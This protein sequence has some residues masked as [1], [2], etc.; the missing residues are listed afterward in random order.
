MP[1]L[2]PGCRKLDPSVQD[3][4]EYTI[5]LCLLCHSSLERGEATIGD[6]YRASLAKTR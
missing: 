6:Q 2:C 4:P 1:P 3:W 5:P